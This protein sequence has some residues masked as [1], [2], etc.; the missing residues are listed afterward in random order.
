MP[1]EVRSQSHPNHY[2]MHKYWGRKAHN[3]VA[4]YIQHFSKK[5]DTILDPFMGSGGVLIESKKIGRSSIGVDINPI[6]E[7][8]V[9]STLSEVEPAQ[10]LAAYKSIII[11]IPDP[12]KDLSHTIC[13]KCKQKVILLN[14]VWQDDVL[15]RIKG[16]CGIHNNFTKDATRFDKQLVKKAKTLLQEYEKQPDFYYPKDKVLDFVRRNGKYTVDTL[17]SSRNLLQSAVILRLI[18]QM[19]DEKIQQLCLLAF[20]SMLPNVSSMIPADKEHVTGKSGWQISKFWV[21]SCHTEK[22]IFISF[23]SRINK[24]YKGKLETVGSYSGAA[25]EVQIT[26]AENLSFIASS[27]IDYIFTDPPYGDSIAY[28]GLSMFWNAWLKSNVDYESEIIYDRYRG[29]DEKDYSLRLNKVYSELFRVLKPGKYMSFT[30]HNR[31]LK[32]WKILIDSVINQGFV[33]TE[34]RWQPQAV[35][36]GTQGINRS[37]TLKGDF[38]YTFKKPLKNRQPQMLLDTTGESLVYKITKKLIQQTG[39][40]ETAALYEQII[41]AIVKERAFLNSQGK[42]LNIDLFLATEFQYKENEEGK[43]GWTT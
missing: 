18:N 8:I 42:I 19:T 38:V 13:P 15:I 43:H 20:T 11:N 3:L 36:S 17:F 28:L 33:L 5:G 14:S 6:T 23:E 29:K 21:P 39:F 32:F 30:F 40:V 22:N 16:V 27:S 37:N 35:D 31:K 7:L 4:S 34:V 9:E 25:H 2:L 24:I 1:E 10:L 26:S 12:V 41:P